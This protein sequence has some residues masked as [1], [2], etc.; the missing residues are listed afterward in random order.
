MEVTLLARRSVRA[1]VLYVHRGCFRSAYSVRFRYRNKPGVELGDIATIPL[2]FNE[3]GRTQPSEQ[4][5]RPAPRFFC[6]VFTH[7][8]SVQGDPFEARL[9]YMTSV[10]ATPSTADKHCCR[11]CNIA[12]YREN[13][14]ITFLSRGTNERGI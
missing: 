7:E 4:I 13:S 11:Y 14:E 5:P 10:F 12:D 3:K 9:L 8:S 2:D 1:L 6:I